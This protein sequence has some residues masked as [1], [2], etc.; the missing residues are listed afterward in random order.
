MLQIF[1]GW[2]SWFPY[3]PFV[4]KIHFTLMPQYDGIN[5]PFDT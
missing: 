2:F 3:Y 1:L 4:T 5:S